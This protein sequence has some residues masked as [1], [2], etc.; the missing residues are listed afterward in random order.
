MTD[1]E[2]AAEK[3]AAQAKAAKEIA[4]FGAKLDD[5]PEGSRLAANMQL[6][7]ARTHATLETDATRRSELESAAVRA[8]SEAVAT[9]EAAEAKAESI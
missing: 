4:R 6:R 5:A 3:Q 9:I 1:E 7:I 8:H 2:K